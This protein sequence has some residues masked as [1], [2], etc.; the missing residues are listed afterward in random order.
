MTEALQVLAVLAE[1]LLKTRVWI[2]QAGGQQLGCGA[3][4]GSPCLYGPGPRLLSEGHQT[5]VLQ[6][7]SPR[8]DHLLTAADQDPDGI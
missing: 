4:G 8:L 7:C 2:D 6:Q 1:R 3:P 5:V